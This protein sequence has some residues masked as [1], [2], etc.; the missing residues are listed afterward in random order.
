MI[1]HHVVTISWDIRIE[2]KQFAN[3]I[4]TTMQTESRNPAGRH[5]QSIPGNLA[6]RNI[7]GGT[8]VSYI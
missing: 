4:T 7:K 5:Q 1:T 8:H 3:H 2:L 6:L